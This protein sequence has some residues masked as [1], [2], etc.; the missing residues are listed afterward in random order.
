MKTARGKSGKLILT[1]QR[2]IFEAEKEQETLAKAM[3]GARY[4]TLMGFQLPQISNFHLDKAA[5]W[6]FISDSRGA[7]PCGANPAAR[8]DYSISSPIVRVGHPPR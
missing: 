8:W 7:H 6:E 1:S 2:L 5:P 3:H 4:V